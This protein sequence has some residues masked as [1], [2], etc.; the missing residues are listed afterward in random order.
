ML[1]TG[2]GIAVALAVVIAIWFLF[3]GSSFLSV[4]SSDTAQETVAETGLPTTNEQQFMITDTEVGTGAEAVAGATVS[5]AYVG[6]LENGQVFDASENHGGPYTFVLGQGAVI[7]GWDQGLLGMKVG[8]KRTLVI[9]P[10]LGYGAQ[11]VGPIPA[12]STLI[13]DVELTDVR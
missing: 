1:V 12:N 9:P 2:T 3:F 13:F 4:F 8:G 11:A 5:V 6:R 7:Q 10:E